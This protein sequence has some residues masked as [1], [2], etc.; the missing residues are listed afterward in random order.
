[1]RTQILIVEDSRTQAEV[2]RELLDDAGYAVAV[3]TNG[4]EGLERFAAVQPDIVVSDILMPG[5]VDG[6]QLCRRIKQSERND[7]PVVLLTG[8][9]D[10][11]DII[12][13]LEC[14]A[15]NFV[16]KPYDPA[17]LLERLQL[18]LATRRARARDRVYAGTRVVFMGRE[19]TVTATREQILDLLVTTFEEAVRQNRELRKRQEEVTLAQAQL[20]R[21]AG[22]LAH[23]FNSLLSTIFVELDLGLADL[24]ADHPL[25]ET[26]RQVRR[27]SEQA[28][29]L[30]QQLLASSRRPVLEPTA[31]TS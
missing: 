29:F 12:R 17:H 3:A 4:E 20:A 30:T 7:T 21:L 15:D 18:L 1:M 10:P 27:A 2:L 6:Y 24:P 26:L 5:P 13:G 9:A 19:F 11:M 23:D 22:G 8:L 25:G 16:T 31:T 14:G 28:A